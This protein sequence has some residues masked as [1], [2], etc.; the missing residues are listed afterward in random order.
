MS[1]RAHSAI[2]CLKATFGMLQLPFCCV[3]VGVRGW[4][5]VV[6]VGGWVCGGRRRG[7]SLIL[8]TR[9]IRPPQSN[10]K[11]NC[12]LP[13]HCGHDSVLSTAVTDSTSNG[14]VSAVLLAGWHLNRGMATNPLPMSVQACNYHALPQQV[15]N[16]FNQD[17]HCNNY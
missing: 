9:L 11:L 17:G 4:G 14:F 5:G 12:L 7:G 10:L 2:Q 8:H 3:G 15:S 1:M 13:V 16:L 6:G